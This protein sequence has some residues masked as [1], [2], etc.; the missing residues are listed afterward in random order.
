V[1]GLCLPSPGAP[2][3]P[4]FEAVR[5]LGPVK[6]LVAPNRV[7]HVHFKPWS[8]RF[9]EA[10]TWGAPGLAKRRPDIPFTAELGNE[11]PSTWR[12]DLDQLL[13]SG[14]DVLHEVVFFH[15]RSKTLVVT[16]ILQNHEPSVDSWFWRTVKRANGIEAPNGGAPRD[17]R[18]TVWKR[19][20]ARRARD[21]IL[22]WDIDRLVLSHGR[23]LPENARPFVERAFEWLG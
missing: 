23:C 14:S 16:D 18:L 4:R 19:A 12:D 11:T 20:E 1:G 22:T 7:H 21:T 15:P 6:H 3:A 17:W 8:E 2:P 13:F 10:Q 5:A 9:P